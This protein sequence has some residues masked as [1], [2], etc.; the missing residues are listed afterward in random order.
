MK[1]K[2]KANSVSLPVWMDVAI[3]DLAQAHK[4]SISGEI[5]FLVEEAIKNSAELARFVPQ[6]GKNDT[7]P[8]A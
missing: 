4:R 1:A 8:A 2:R 7:L 3:R 6:V 5:E